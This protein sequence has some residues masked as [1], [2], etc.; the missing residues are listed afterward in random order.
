[1]H[2][3]FKVD[4]CVHVGDMSHYLRILRLH[5]ITIQ[6]N[7]NMCCQPLTQRST[8]IAGFTL[9]TTCYHVRDHWGLLIGIIKELKNIREKV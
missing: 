8:Q 5:S 3:V 2:L 9:P 1:M 4:I 6:S 7:K